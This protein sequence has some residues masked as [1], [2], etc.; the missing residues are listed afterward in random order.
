MDYHNQKVLI[1]GMGKSGMAA[2]KTLAGRGAKVTLCDHQP[3]AIAGS[4]YQKLIQA[5]VAIVS[6]SYPSGNWDLVVVS[7][8]VPLTEEPVLKALQAG[9]R[10]WGELELA[11][12]LKSP[13]LSIAAVTGTNGKTTTTALLGEIFAAQGWPSAVAGNIGIPLITVVEG[14][15][16]GWVACEV[17][18][19]QLETT[20]EFRPRVAGIINITPDHLD[21]HHT[22]EA[23]IA[24]KAQVFSHMQTNDILVLNYDDELVRSL[25]SQ[26]KCQVVFC[27]Q[28]TKIA[29]GVY[30]QNGFIHADYCGIGDLVRF[31]STRLRGGHN[32]ENLLVATAMAL[33]AGIDAQVLG[34]ALQKFAGVRHRLEEV[35]VKAGAL[36]INDSKGTNPDST[37]KALQSFSQPV[38]LIAG[39][40]HKGG[41]LTELTELVKRQVRVLVLLGE[42]RN[43]IKQKMESLGFEAIIE[44]QNLEEAV[45]V[46]YKNS[47]PGEVVLLSPA[48]A[49]WD[50]FKNYE[51]RGDLFCSLVRSLPD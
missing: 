46:A 24:S 16:T 2:A 11:Y 14:M 41:D 34:P 21:R 12:Q 39:G 49:S 29:G 15:S 13:D 37:I 31:D 33:A 38:I 43:I 3:I 1:I 50:M 40:R 48:C 30:Y 36:Y 5:G 7:P 6:G 18:S 32:L 27:S 10:V 23:Y 26:A 45:E 28:K 47:Q 19:F 44:V 51:Q 8:G 25:A 17:S 4:G 35:A 9:K 20:Q 42:A 22:M